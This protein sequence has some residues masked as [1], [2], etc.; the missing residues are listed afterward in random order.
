MASQAQG[1]SKDDGPGQQPVSLVIPC[2]AEYVGLCRVLAGVVGARGS[3]HAEDIADLKLVVTEAC[4]C[5]LPG[6]QDDEMSTP[7]K[8]SEGPPDSLRVD[9]QI[10]PSIWEVTV[11]DADR[12][13]IIPD[14]SN[15]S[16]FGSGGL[17][18]TIMRALV[19][20]L[21]HTYAERGGSV[22]R[23]SKRTDTRVGDLS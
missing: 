12:R 18:L 14:E 1:K 23:M 8:S 16:P 15:C 5:F 17:G 9:F 13:H 20:S 2:R 7:C 3:L 6:Y 10:G 19:D 22:I 11:S 21:E 4:A